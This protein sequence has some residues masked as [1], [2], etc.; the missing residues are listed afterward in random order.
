LGEKGEIYQ[1]ETYSP[2]NSISHEGK[3]KAIFGLLLSF[4]KAPAGKYRLIL[5]IGQS[6]SAETTRLE[7]DLELIK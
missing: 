2:K 1:G 4:S 3:S 6:D 7:T 5:E